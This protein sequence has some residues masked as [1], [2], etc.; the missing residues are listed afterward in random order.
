MA[1]RS[2]IWRCEEGREAREKQQQAQRGY[3]RG[4]QPRRSYKDTVR[5][6][7]GWLAC[8]AS[9]LWILVLRT[10]ASFDLSTAREIT[11]MRTEFPSSLYPRHST[12]R[13]PPAVFVV[14]ERSYRTDLG[15]ADDNNAG[16]D[17]R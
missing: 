17:H 15:T 9:H 1:W 3:V 10:Q 14:L 12:S 8:T 11:L 4:F 6:P 7:A 5:L 16:E 13:I 2:E